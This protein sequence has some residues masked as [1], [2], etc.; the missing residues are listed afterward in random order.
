VH[1]RC[2]PLSPSPVAAAVVVLVIV[3][4]LTLHSQKWGAKY[5]WGVFDKEEEEGEDEDENPPPGVIVRSAIARARRNIFGGAF[6][7]WMLHERNA[8]FE[9]VL[10]GGGNRTYIT[11]VDIRGPF[12]DDD[13]DDDNDD[14]ASTSSASP[15]SSYF[16]SFP[17]EYSPAEGEPDESYSLSV[18][19]DGRAVI[20]AHSAIGVVRALD[21]FS[22]LFYQHSGRPP[23]NAN[24]HPGSNDAYD[25][26]DNDEDDEAT[27][28]AASVV[29]TT[30]APLR[31]HDWPRF[32]HRGLN[33]DVA[34]A[35]YPPRA[36]RRTLDIAA[37]HKLNRLH[38]H[39]TDAQA[40]PL[41]VPALPALAQRGA[42]CTAYGYGNGRRRHRCMYTARDLRRLRAAAARRGVAI[43][44]EID[45]PGHAGSI[46][47]AFPALV[48]A[49][50]VRPHWGAYAAEP[51]SGQLKLNSSAVDTFVRT[52][53]DDV[54]PRV[55]GRRPDI[56]DVGDENNKKRNIDSDDQQKDMMGGG[57]DGGGGG[58]G[59][60][61]AGS[62]GDDGGGGS[63]AGGRGLF[64]TGGDELNLDVYLLDETVRS[65][66]RAVLQPLLQRFVDIVHARVRAHG[67][68]PVVW[69]ELLLDWNLTLGADVVV[70]TWRSVESLRYVTELGHKAIAGNFQYWVFYQRHLSASFSLLHNILI[71]PKVPRLRAWLVAPSTSCS[72]R[73][74]RD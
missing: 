63:G 37:Q 50:D 40:W 66:K 31:I 23:L 34:R 4:R 49:F 61:D 5:E 51:P 56:D 18:A 24:T 67:L 33:L 38:L 72:S 69:E 68:V 8:D 28:P 2:P 43:V 70:Q 54:L 14:G 52:L 48:A 47:H 36:L 29:Y 21:T 41:A 9:P 6:V 10:D 60:S 45:L 35:W 12:M 19:D 17:S 11:R 53:L 57:D 16:S 71:I 13:D 46:A 42:Y 59:N 1:Q 64:H 58:G 44:A 62:A 25:D 27:A 20:E 32:A 74:R 3:A 7:P 22:Q 39:F 65:N 15:A 26:D 55:G 73:R 30:L